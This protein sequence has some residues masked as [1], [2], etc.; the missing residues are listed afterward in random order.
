MQRAR[1]QIEEQMQQRYKE[2]DQVRCAC[3]VAAVLQAPC[4]AY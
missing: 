4:C 1:E 2:F 3:W